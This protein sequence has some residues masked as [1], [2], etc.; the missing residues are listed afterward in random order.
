[1][2]LLP[3]CRGWWA[4]KN[5]LP[6]LQKSCRVGSTSR[7]GNVFLLPTCRGWWAKKTLCPPYKRTSLGLK[8]CFGNGAERISSRRELPQSG[9]KSC[10]RARAKPTIFAVRWVSFHSTHPTLATLATL[11][12]I[13]FQKNKRYQT[14]QAF[15]PKYFSEKL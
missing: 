2:F 4:K 6:T 11:A 7:V 1:V 8:C 12:A 5:T 15:G 9:L 3:T 10:S 14:C 13:A